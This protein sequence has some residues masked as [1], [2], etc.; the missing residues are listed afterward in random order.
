MSDVTPHDPDPP[1]APT[2]G[3]G[4]GRSLSRRLRAVAGLVPSGA[5]PVD[6]GAGGGRLPLW[7]LHAGQVRRCIATE[8]TASVGAALAGLG[9]V[10]G[11]VVRLGDGLA[12]LR[13]ED[14]PDVLVLSGL[15]ARSMLRIFQDGGDL[16]LRFRRLVL[17]P[18][19][20]AGRLR[21]WLVERGHSIVDERMVR[22]RGR[23][24][25]VIAA[26]PR[27]GAGPPKHPGLSADDLMQ[28]GPCL[29]RSGAPLVCSYWQQVA[30]RTGRVLDRVGTGPGRRRAAR[31]WALAARILV[32]LGPPRAS[33]TP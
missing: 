28:V 19:T 2:A 18:Q 4:P 29:V 21:T 14:R 15:G 5:Y 24:Y 22:E 12:A 7:L 13:P 11:L 3:R 30:R 6:V 8:R 23:F 31:Q 27:P 1:R 25:V 10:A 26:E 9:H 20:E 16:L 32:A 17:Q 33:G